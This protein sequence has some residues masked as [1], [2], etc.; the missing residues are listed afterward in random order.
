LASSPDRRGGTGIRRR[1]TEDD[2]EPTRSSKKSLSEEYSGLRCEA[3]PQN[4]RRGKEDEA[5][6]RRPRRNATVREK[7]R[8]TDWS[9]FEIGCILQTI[10]NSLKTM[11]KRNSGLKRQKSNSHKTKKRLEIKRLM[12]EEKAKKHKNKK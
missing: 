2:R 1:R 11:A 4:A 10:I 6:L 8:N 3:F 12:L 7:R 9:I 5:G